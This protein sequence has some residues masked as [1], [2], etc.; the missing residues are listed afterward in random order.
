MI[1]KPIAKESWKFFDFKALEI[2]QDQLDLF[3]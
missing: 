2:K 1:V 3:I